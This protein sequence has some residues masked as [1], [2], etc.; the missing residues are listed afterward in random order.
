MRSRY[1]EGLFSM[2]LDVKRQVLKKL[3]GAE[4]DN[5]NNKAIFWR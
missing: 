5:Q 4:N 2:N 3:T 1:V